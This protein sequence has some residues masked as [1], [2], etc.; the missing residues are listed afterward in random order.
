MT[1][2]LLLT[3][4]VSLGVL[5]AWLLANAVPDRI[6]FWLNIDFARERKKPPGGSLRAPGAAG[7]KLPDA[8]ILAGLSSAK[9]SAADRAG[10]AK[11]GKI[12]VHTGTA[13]REQ[14]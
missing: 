12:M 1:S 11:A 13:K 9:L 8:E 5:P 10:R 2:L 4:Q 7:Q 3:K 14:K 6:Q